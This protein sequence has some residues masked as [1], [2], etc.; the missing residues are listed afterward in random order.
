MLQRDKH[1]N[2][3]TFGMW[4]TPH[5]QALLCVDIKV[6]LVLRR[7]AVHRKVFSP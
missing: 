4:D 5:S 3:A 1:F 7:L 2:Q 6:V